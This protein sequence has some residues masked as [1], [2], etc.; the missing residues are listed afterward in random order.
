L[1]YPNPTLGQWIGL[2]EITKNSSAFLA[3]LHRC[4]AVATL[5]EL[6]MTPLIAVATPEELSHCN[7]L[8]DFA[9]PQPAS[10]LSN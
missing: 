7:E 8:V 6:V 4:S 2:K 10:V 9:K 3:N 5:T 1:D